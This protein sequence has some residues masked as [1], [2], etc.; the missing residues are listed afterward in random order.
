MPDPTVTADPND[1]TDLQVQNLNAALQAA[2]GLV[3][4]PGI[5][6]DVASMGGNVPAAARAV[7]QAGRRQVM[8]S[9]AATINTESGGGLWHALSSGLGDVDKI[10]HY[11][12]EGTGGALGDVVGAV[13]K[14]ANVPLSG[15]Q[16]EWR[17][18]HEVDA[19]EGFGAALVEG[20]AITGLVAAGT[21]LTGGMGDV[22]MAAFGSTM[23]DA[24]AEDGAGSV[25]VGAANAADQAAGRGAGDIL[26]GGLKRVLNANGGRA[27]LIN[28]PTGQVAGQVAFRQAW[29]KT[30]STGYVDPK[31]GQK[32]SF[33]RD[34]ASGLFHLD[35]QSGTY[36]NLSGVLDGLA[37]I[38]G[39]P[40]QAAGQQVGAAKSLQGPQNLLS[41]MGFR[42]N[43]M[44]LDDFEWKASEQSGLA[45]AKV[46]RFLQF[47]AENGGAAIGR[48]YPSLDPIIADKDYA[49]NVD[50]QAQ[51]SQ[52]LAEQSD[53]KDRLAFR[54]KVL[55]TTGN[56]GIS[57]LEDEGIPS[58]PQ[59][60]REH[61]EGQ[62]A[63]QTLRAQPYLE[64]LR[65][66]EV[67]QMQGR[68]EELHQE[69][70]NIPTVTVKGLHGAS[71]PDEVADVLKNRVFAKGESIG[72]WI[73]SRTLLK[74]SFSKTRDI[75]ANSDRRL[76][77]AANRA[78]S[79]IPG[80]L[81]RESRQWTT[82]FG[83]HSL[84]RMNNL[85]QWLEPF[86]GRDA[87][88]EIVNMMY[89]ADPEG[90]QIIFR[91]AALMRMNAMAGKV[92]DAS[93]LDPHGEEAAL[94]EITDPRVQEYM[95][96][97]IDEH[98]P[99]VNPEA[100]DVYGTSLTGERPRP[101]VLPSG[102]KRA[103]AQMLSQ[104]Q[105][106]VHLPSYAQM[107]EAGRILKNG[108]DY[109]G[110]VD[111][112]M[113]DHVSSYIRPAMLFS[114]GFPVHMAG[115]E[116]ME[117]VN[118]EGLLPTLR[119]AVHSIAAKWGYRIQDSELPSLLDFAYRHIPEGVKNSRE[120]EKM[121]TLAIG[122]EGHQI[123]PDNMASHFILDPDMN[124]TKV[125]KGFKYILGDNYRLTN[126]EKPLT[127]TGKEVRLDEDA[128]VAEI[129]NFR[130]VP[131][132]QSYLR[133]MGRDPIFK[134]GAQAAIDS[135]SDRQAITAAMRE[136]MDRL[137]TDQLA[138][139]DAAKYKTEGSPISKTP[140][141]DWADQ[142]TDTL[143]AMTHRVRAA[144]GAQRTITAAPHALTPELLQGIIDGRRPSIKSLEGLG[145]EDRPASV[146][147]REVVPVPGQHMLSTIVTDGF[148]KVFTSIVHKMAR[149]PMMAREFSK[150]YDL[151]EPDVAR[152]LMT[153]DQMVTRALSDAA[154]ENTRYQHNPMERTYFDMMTRNFL[155]FFFAQSQAYR[156]AGRLLLENPGAFRRYQLEIAGVGNYVAQANS[157]EGNP[158]ILIPGSGFMTHAMVD[159]LGLIAPTQGINPTGYGGTISSLNVVFPMSQGPRPDVSP[160][161]AAP[162]KMLNSLFAQEALSFKD[163][164]PVN[165]AAQDLT[166]VALGPEGQTEATWEAASP[167]STLTRA[168]KAMGGGTSRT[169]TMLQI[170]ANLAYQQQEAYATWLDTGK[171]GPEPQ[172][173][174]AADTANAADIST[175][176]AKV[177][178]QTTIAY[179]GSAALGLVSPIGSDV[180]VKDFGLSEDLTND[181]T[182][183]G[184]VNGYTHFHAQHPNATP[185][186]VAKSSTI[187]NIPLKDSIA[188]MQWVQDR[189]PDIQQNPSLLYLMPQSLSDK[190]NSVAYSQQV[191]D[192][193]R[194][195]DTPEQ[196]VNNIYAAQFAQQY[197]QGYDQL[198]TLLAANKGNTP[199]INQLYSK[200]DAFQSFLR[201]Q[202][203][204]GYQTFTDNNKGLTAGAVIS[205]LRRAFQDGTAPPGP[206]TT[207]VKSLLS[208][209]DQVEN[210]YVQ[211]GTQSNYSSAQSS[212]RAQ[213]QVYCQNVAKEIP[214][215]EPVIASV[216][217]DALTSTNPS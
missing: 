31:T 105:D 156:R 24:V 146:P 102:Q 132:W 139:M 202:N 143:L 12:N 96:K 59:D 164:Q 56:A 158:Y 173:I 145:L 53:L 62:A 210:A 20:L 19:K 185:Y 92:A 89:D 162:L 44:R 147:G 45:G 60:V 161:V 38:F 110:A 64:H 37:D 16:H 144:A 165:Q 174:P 98:W 191:A 9:E 36:K 141:D 204:V 129:E 189:L 113:E 41:D 197:F 131:D 169:S 133:Q 135:G 82:T 2:P 171:K 176:L 157:S 103:V 203:P 211:A 213:W 65:T 108:H 172:I 115:A 52:M 86:I 35:P 17:Y 177:R 25:D 10:A 81:D 106:E 54:Q 88:Y 123:L 198:T 116:M 28:Y 58:L 57:D 26:K 179:W 63:N 94:Q 118:K 67:P 80:A 159:G 29:Q 73:P 100:T 127:E 7:D 50:Q 83:L 22:D 40:L 84:S 152:G 85:T 27:A 187:D 183:Y 107:R 194:F 74:E 130:K 93:L 104:A 69:I 46:R 188:A 101:R 155:P 109:F 43:A 3:K 175:F 170:I 13:T 34:I 200:W 42:G 120:Y 78:T 199:M 142:A 97:F 21:V 217:R 48:E 95:R 76:V 15:V 117:Y 192:G 90:R 71:T 128:K 184:E 11:A 6:N 126:F 205:G 196:F 119:A 1:P 160:I 87:T 47:A 149:E 212:I 215:L 148:S 68:L 77:Q 134:A 207:R 206:Q 99:P 182:K 14:A 66:T 178:N 216:F 201:T 195:R 167:N 208:V 121:F 75:F 8:L 33:G 32:V 112:W 180:T 114:G 136:A 4:S 91:N 154:I 168:I 124:A 55:R 79:K 163:F 23:G 166:G 61:L 39:D 186:T 193:L 137:S 49:E 190:Y 140:L 138:T 72:P 209:F 122:T 150:L 125:R 51:L 153:H 70:E 30:A 151:Y 214:Q 181:L 111:T 5:A 18:L